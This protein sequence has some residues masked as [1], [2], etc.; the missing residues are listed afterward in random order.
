MPYHIMKLVTTMLIYQNAYTGIYFEKVL[1]YLLFFLQKLVIQ[2][3]EVL[4][5]MR[6]SFDKPEAMRDLF[7]R[8]GSKLSKILASKTS[9][10]CISN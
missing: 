7:R 3:K 4:F 8:L 10:E 2:N 9:Q 1:N 5:N 6:T